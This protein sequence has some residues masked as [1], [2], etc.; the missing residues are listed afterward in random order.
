MSDSE[1]FAQ[2]F[3]WKNLRYMKEVCFQKLVKIVVNSKQE[4]VK[5]KT[6]FYSSFLG[7]KLPSFP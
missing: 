6:G 5:P 7:V 1:D 4:F 2:I 3:L